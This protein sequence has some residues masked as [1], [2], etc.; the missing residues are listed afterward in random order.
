QVFDLLHIDGESLL[1]QPLDARKAR[2]RDVLRE[3]PLVRS[4]GHVE[5]DGEALFASVKAEG[6]EGVMAKKRDSRYESARRSH[7]WLK[8]KT[9][10][11]QECVV[12]GWEPG[13]VAHRDLGSL[14]L[15][16]YDDD[17]RFLF[18][19]EVGSG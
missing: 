17:G 6:L 3:H 16:V 5:A 19:G 7:A 8:I 13:S 10:P 4:P 9:A 18:A 12:A 11:E 15:G 14:V 2:L 1:D